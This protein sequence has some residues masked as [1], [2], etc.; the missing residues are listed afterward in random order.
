[1][2]IVLRH[3]HSSITRTAI[4]ERSLGDPAVRT[5]CVTVNRVDA[6]AGIQVHAAHT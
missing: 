4:D 2:V 6:N 5:R 3:E 1:L